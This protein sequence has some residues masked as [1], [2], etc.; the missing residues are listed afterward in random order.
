VHSLRA[1]TQH[2]YACTC[3]HVPDLHKQ[4]FGYWDGHRHRVELHDGVDTVTVS[5]LNWFYCLSVMLSCARYDCSIEFVQGGMVD[6]FAGGSL[7]I[8][9]L[10]A[11]RFSNRVGI[12]WALLRCSGLRHGGWGQNDNTRIIIHMIVDAYSRF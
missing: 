8:V 1:R 6:G 2:V 12:T 7:S 9:S 5:C 10:H 11:V 3:V 4:V